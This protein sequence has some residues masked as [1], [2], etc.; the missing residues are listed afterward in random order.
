MS[1]RA[2]AHVSKETAQ[3]CNIQLF[4]GDYSQEGGQKG[5]EGQMANA[6]LVEGA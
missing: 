6:L 4:S 1:P 5:H 3:T 2:S